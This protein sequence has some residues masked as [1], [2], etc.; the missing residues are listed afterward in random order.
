MRRIPFFTVSTKKIP[1]PAVRQL[2]LAE[3]M[4]LLK[5]CLS[6]QNT[7][8]AKTRHYMHKIHDKNVVANM[9]QDHRQQLLQ[10]WK[11]CGAVRL[12]PHACGSMYSFIQPSVLRQLHCN[13]RMLQDY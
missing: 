3:Y 6:V 10:Y 2:V 9:P 7:L 4:N 11:H 13:C 1:E 5:A 8:L 12:V